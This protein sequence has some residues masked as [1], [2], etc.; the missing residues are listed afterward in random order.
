MEP[1]GTRRRYGGRSHEER[2]EARRT[3]LVDAGYDLFGSVGY[4]T[5][6]IEQLCRHAHLTARNLYEEFG[7]REG[8]LRA[9]YDRTIDR[10]VVDVLAALSEAR[11]DPRD[12]SQRAISAFARA[13]LEDPRA[14]RIVFLEVIGVSEAM[15]HHRRQV[16]RAFADLV[17][18]EAGR[19]VDTGLVVS[20]SHPRHTA[21]ALVGGVNELIVDWL[22]SDDRIPVDELVTAIADLF[23][24]AAAGPPDRR[25]P[26]G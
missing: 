12:R 10:A 21:L 22:V 2:R 9:V 19:L 14:A 25:R 8:L 18:E 24:A 15:E 11:D 20:R 4:R 17:A 7:D 3:A 26:A 16:L 1:A 13:M 6:S 5:V 23:V